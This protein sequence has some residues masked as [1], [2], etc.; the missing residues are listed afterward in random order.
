MVFRIRLVAGGRHVLGRAAYVAK[1]RD[2][3]DDSAIDQR[4][5]AG[6]AVELAVEGAKAIELDERA[7]ALKGEDR[8]SY[9]ADTRAT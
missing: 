8:A 1:G 2:P 6:R 9:G 3:V 7:R 5:S 4:H